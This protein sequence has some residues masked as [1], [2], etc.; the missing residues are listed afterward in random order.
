MN[1]MKPNRAIAL[2]SS[3]ISPRYS[4]ALQASFGPVKLFK[5]NM[6]FSFSAEMSGILYYL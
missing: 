2:L 1:D 5:S 3:S 4:S 6:F